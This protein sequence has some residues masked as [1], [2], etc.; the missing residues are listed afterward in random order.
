M[1]YSSQKKS[2]QTSYATGNDHW[3]NLPL[4]TMA[5]ELVQ[6][7]QPGAMV[8]DIGSGRG[9]FPFE[10]AKNGFKV[11]GMEIIPS[12]VEKNN[13]E[14]KN[15]KLESKIRFI[16]GDVLD[17]PLSDESFD[18]VADIG[19]LQHIHPEDWSE[20]RNE[21]ARVLKSGA[22]FFLITLSK[23]TPSFLSWKPKNTAFK[24]FAQDGMFYHFFTSEEINI[25]FENDF[26]MISERTETVEEH[27]DRV[28]YIITLMKKK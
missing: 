25:L 14:V 19:L 7:L 28:L 16:E 1:D 6:A 21:V 15:F 4:R 3:T 10:L 17:I 8:L 12:I 22:Y 27:S 23:N 18:A 11:I 9:K 13:T 2:F 24:D 5:G 20:Y 26:T